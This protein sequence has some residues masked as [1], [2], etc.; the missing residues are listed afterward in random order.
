[1]S[2]TAAARRLEAALEMWADGVE[3]MRENPQRKF[4]N[5]G[6]TEI[7]R[8]VAAWLADRPLDA[9]GVPRYRRRR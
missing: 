3:I 8:K 2:R 4:P 1:M 7:Q 5:A 6:R 9:T